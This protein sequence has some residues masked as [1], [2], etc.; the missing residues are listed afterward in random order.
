M[1]ESLEARKERLRDELVDYLFEI[2]EK[3]FDVRKIE[4]LLD[5][6]DAIA[7]I[8]KDWKPVEESLIEFWEKYNPERAQQLAEEYATGT[9]E[10][11]GNL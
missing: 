9:C 2:P 6:I 5:E 7:P 3:D 10:N 8:P 11:T 4:K 1:D